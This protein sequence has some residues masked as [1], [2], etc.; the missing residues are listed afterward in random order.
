MIKT[1]GLQ[2]YTIRDHMKD[3]DE[4]RQSFKKL[5][6]LGYTEAQTAGSGGVSHSELGELAKECGIKIVGTHYGFDFMESN[7]EQTIADHKALGTTN[8]GIGGYW[9]LTTKDEVEAFIKRA[10][11]VADKLYEHGLKFTYHNHS[12]EFKKVDGNVSAWDMLIDGLNPEKTSFV[13]DTCWIAN[14][15]GDVCQWIEKLAG[16]IDILHLKDRGYTM[17]DYDPESDDRYRLDLMEVGGGNLNWD[18]IIKSAEKAGIKYYCVEQDRNF[19][20]GTA[21][22]YLKKSADFLKK[23]M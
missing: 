4:I 16:R 23:Y 13:L 8:C 3:A 21:F 14:A 18:G 9:A 22:D 6:E 17:I 2:L 5:K 19:T 10:N 15:G 12:H 11:A 1:L 20:E 7:F